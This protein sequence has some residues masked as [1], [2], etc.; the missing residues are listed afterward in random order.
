MIV[1]PINHVPG[2]ADIILGAVGYY[3]I[4]GKVYHKYA[5]QLGSFLNGILIPGSVVGEA[6]PSA[7][8][9]T[10]NI[11]EVKY[12]DLLPNPDSPTGVG[13]VFQ[14]RNHISFVTPVLLDGTAGDGA[15]KTQVNT[16]VVVIQLCNQD[17]EDMMG[18]NMGRCLNC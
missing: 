5:V 6:V 13:A 8:V 14:L 11:V 3:F 10:H 1:G 15:D 9:I 17:P 2:S 18:A 7:M 16:S 4:I 12:S